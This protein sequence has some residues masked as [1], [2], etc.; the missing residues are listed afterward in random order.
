MAGRNPYPPANL[1]TSSTAPPVVL[2]WSRGLTAASYNVYRDRKLLANQAA[3]SY[4]DN[5]VTANSRHKY[6]VTSVDAAG[7]ESDGSVLDVSIEPSGQLT[8]QVVWTPQPGHLGP[9]QPRWN[10]G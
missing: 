1:A 9:P 5:G 4:S 3:L 7:N 6:M 8:F 10:W 2:T